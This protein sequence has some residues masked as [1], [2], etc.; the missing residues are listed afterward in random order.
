M[1]RFRFRLERLLELRRYRER[2]WELKLAAVT[3]RCLKIEQEIR[4]RQGEMIRNIGDRSW[5]KGF[6]DMNHLLSMELYRARLV[7]EKEMLQEELEIKRAE[8]QRVQEGYLDASKHR[9][10]LDKLRQRR[11][12]EYYGQQKKED[13]K[14]QDD[15]TTGSRARQ[16]IT[17]G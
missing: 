2:E 10:V 3:G 5:P 11:E 1:H 15:I 7:R 4:S 13:F 16:K 9:K 14:V 6:L 12:A 17:G 8:Q